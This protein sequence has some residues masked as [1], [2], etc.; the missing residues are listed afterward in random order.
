MT[1]AF[2]K[3]PSLTSSLHKMTNEC[4]PFSHL[5]WVDVLRNRDL[6]SHQDVTYIYSN[7]GVPSFG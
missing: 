4:P 5:L 3:Y 7:G 2:K 1:R 6:I